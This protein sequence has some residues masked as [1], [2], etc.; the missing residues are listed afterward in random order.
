MVA[1]NEDS[2]GNA[3]LPPLIVVVVFD[4]DGARQAEQ[5]L[6]FAL[7]MKVCVI[8]VQPRRLVVRHGDLI[9]A[10]ACCARGRLALGNEIRGDDVV[11]RGS[12]RTARHR[13]NLEAVEMQVGVA[14]W[15]VIGARH[16]LEISRNVGNA[17]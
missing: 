1:H 17:G 11:A 7:A 9:G 8:P 14:G 16:N 10:L 4:H 15:L 12:A 3:V 6:G 13:L 5:G 2:I